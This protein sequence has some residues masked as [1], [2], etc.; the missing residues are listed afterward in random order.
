MKSYQLSG[1]N[2]GK[3]GFHPNG[4]QPMSRDDLERL[5]KER[6]DIIHELGRRDESNDRKSTHDRH[7]FDGNRNTSRNNYPRSGFRRNF[8]DQTSRNHFRDRQQNARGN[9]HRSGEKLVEVQSDKSSILFRFLYAF[10]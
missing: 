10:L 3:A 6:K 2:D 7:S 8:N 1:K 4:K 5:R 9:F